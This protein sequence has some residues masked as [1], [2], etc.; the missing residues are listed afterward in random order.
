MYLLIAK[1]ALGLSKTLVR[2]AIKKIPPFKKCQIFMG[3]EQ[4][5]FSTRVC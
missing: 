4:G 1:T 2:H 5:G 3:N